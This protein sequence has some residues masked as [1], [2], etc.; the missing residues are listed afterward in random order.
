MFL[1]SSRGKPQD[2]PKLTTSN[3][4][5]KLHAR[6]GLLPFRSPLLREFSSLKTRDKKFLH[7]RSQVLAK[8]LFLFLRLLKC[9]ASAGLH[10]CPCGPS[11]SI[12][13]RVGFPHSEIPGLK[14]ARHLSEAYRSHATSFFASTSQGI[15]HP[16]VNIL[17]SQI[18]Q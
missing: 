10:S 12:Y 6:S 14:V 3:T 7:L 13:H 9:F 16:P 11:N 1:D 18:S 15:H 17:S 4:Q 5:Q 2:I 8:S